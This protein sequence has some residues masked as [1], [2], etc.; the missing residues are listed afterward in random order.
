M[1]VGPG[2]ERE[3]YINVMTSTPQVA[4]RPGN[5]R[6]GYINIMSPNPQVAVGPEGRVIFSNM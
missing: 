5:E 3:G 1:A 6:D 4:S 2:R